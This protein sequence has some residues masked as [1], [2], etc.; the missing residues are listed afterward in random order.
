MCRVLAYL[1]EPVLLDHL[2][3][4][5]DNSLIHQTYDPKMSTMLNLAGFGLAAWDRTSFDP[6]TP[7]RY[8]TTAVPIFDRNLELLSQKLRSHAFIAH[9]RGVPYHTQVTIGEQNLHPFLFEG[10]RLAFAQNGQLAEFDEM[11]FDL[12]EHIRPEFQQ[13]IQ[14]NTDTEWIYALFLSQLDDPGAGATPES[15]ARAVEASFRVLREV[16]ERRGIKVYSPLNLFLS[17][18]ELIAAVRFAFDFGCY[19]TSGSEIDEAMF[20][21]MSLWYTCGR[22]YGLHDGEWRMVGGPSTAPSIILSSEPLSRDRATWLEVPEYTMIAATYRDGV[23]R[24][25]EFSIDA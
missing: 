16:R 24:R 21:F 22:D 3:F 17:D 8:R 13:Q 1:G 7:F 23:V 10:T 20:D 11:R 6:V 9:V 15:I 5:S 14:G 2:L 19:P 12:L 4:K 25:E 18:G